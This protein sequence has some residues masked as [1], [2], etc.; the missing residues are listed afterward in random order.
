MTTQTI[1][2]V[3]SEALRALSESNNEPGWLTEQRLE[4]LKLASGLAL[5]KLEKQKI[6]RWNVSEYGTYKASEA[7][8]S[9]EEVPASIKD[10]VQDQAEGSLVIQRN[11][12]TVYSKVSAD[13][14][15]KGVI[16]TDLATAVREHGDLVK[17]YLNTAVKADEHSL[18]ALHAALWNGGVF[19]YVPKMW[20]LKF[21]FKLFCSQM[22]QL[23]HLHLMSSLL[24]KRTAL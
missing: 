10:L 20:K 23:L 14:A 24:L 11:S 4:A 17:P 22:M 3:E 21:R 13:L 15:A 8:S 9:L 6:E 19:L 1:L 5:P 7:I 12:S 2:P 18:A 16:F